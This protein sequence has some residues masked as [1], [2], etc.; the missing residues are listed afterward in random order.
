M[1]LSQQFGENVFNDAVQKEMLPKEVYKALRDTIESGKRL[2]VGIA[3]AVAAAMKDWAVSKGAT[4][5]THWFQPLTGLTAEKH[6]SFVEK[7]EGDS[8]IMRLTGKSLI[9]GEPDA[10]SFPSAGSR[11][12]YMA[13][14]YTA[15]DPTSP[16]FVKDATLY[17]PTV[18]VSYTG[19][20]L[21]K[22]SP[23]LRSMNAMDRQAKRIL[24]LFGIECNKVATTVGPEQEYFLI[25]E[26]EFN[27]R[28]DL[29]LTGRTLFG[30]PASRGQELEDQYFG[31]LKQRV[32]DY[33]R[34]LDETLWS[35]GI[36][37]KTRHNE[38]APAQHEVAPIYSTSNV[39]VDHNMLTME[40]MKK[41][42]A[43]HGLACLLH[44]KPFEGINGS[45]KHNNWG[46]K[47][48]TGVNM[49]KTGDNPRE[50]GLFLLSLAAV[51]K[52]VDDYQGILRA[53][54]ASAGNDHRL[55]ANEAPPAI[56]SIYL[57]D[58][59]G[60]MVESIVQGRDYVP[61]QPQR[62]SIGVP[63]SPIFPKDATDR[64]RTSP[65]AFTGNKFEF[66]M[67][68]SSANVADPNIVL[69]TIV[70]DAFSKFADELEKAPDFDKA[71][72]KLC[73][74]EIK[75]HHRIIFNM[76]GYNAEWEKEAEKR[77]LLNNKNTADAVKVCFE[78]DNIDVFVR[79]GVY[80]KNEAI[81][82]AQIQLE[83]YAKTINIEALTMLQMAKQDIMP[84]VSDYIANL[85]QN[86]ESKKAVSEK[87]GCRGEIETIEK[88]SALNDE[89]YDAVGKLEADLKP[90]DMD[91]AEG[92]SQ[93]MAHVIIP[94]M[95]KVRTVA[96]EM[97]TMVSADFW[98]YSST[99]DLL[100]SVK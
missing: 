77:G 73:E 16:A 1:N 10:S 85:C 45:G 66:R 100:Y 97:E 26:E 62:G 84:A 53:S 87:I 6:D 3:G 51:L 19:E 7:D 93:T 88:L 83:N 2:D 56:I 46:I 59:L 32:I 40:I 25:T 90:V 58:E 39:A 21:D 91:D 12:T 30:A 78:D 75:A 81:A 5:Y 42:A 20:T 72:D 11:A 98:P 15:W 76:D 57:G 55:G 28:K 96:D 68:G 36:H 33:M 44:E 86:V 13:R 48:D 8:I 99:Y 94:D 64:N 27:K 35:Y 9:V 65:F 50:N 79:Q 52:A 71:L 43:K 22:K 63:E 89:L 17:I 69:N 23:L 92:A 67:M 54:V 80:T 31:V 95:E 37:S 38:V 4:H 18:F 74:R 61:A 24:K 82:R 70:A 29:V 47:T 14:G 49:F 60:E 41:V 34:D